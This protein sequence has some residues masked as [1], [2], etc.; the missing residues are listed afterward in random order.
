MNNH[1]QRLSAGI[2]TLVAGLGGVVGTS[3]AASADTN[4]PPSEISIKPLS[5]G[6]VIETLSL[7]KLKKIKLITN[8]GARGKEML[9]FTEQP[10]VTEGGK[11]FLV[12]PDTGN[13]VR[14]LSVDGVPKA[15]VASWQQVVFAAPQKGSIEVRYGNP[16]QVADAMPVGSATRYSYRVTNMEYSTQPTF[17][18]TITVLKMANAPLVITKPGAVFY[19]YDPIAKEVS[20]GFVMGG[21]MMMHTV[22]DWK[23]AQIFLPEGT[24][25]VRIGST[26]NPSAGIVVA[27]ATKL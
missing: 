12:N 24:L 14:G 11:Y 13:I 1:M 27:K 23:M 5:S 8:L 18:G 4:I 21:D 16:D 22:N 10:Q 6:K 20:S 7:Y 26:S 9:T 2:L 15:T 25:E 17:F 19:T 3:T